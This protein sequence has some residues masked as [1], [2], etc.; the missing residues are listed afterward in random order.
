MINHS[1]PE[2]CPYSNII[3]ATLKK[4]IDEKIVLEG[5]RIPRY[6]FELHD[7]INRT[8]YAP[9]N[10]CAVGI[11]GFPRLWRA[12]ISHLAASLNSPQ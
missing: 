10:S 2:I 5:N 3:I 7:M 1:F 6:Y 8:E 12:I 4:A 11:C 9:F